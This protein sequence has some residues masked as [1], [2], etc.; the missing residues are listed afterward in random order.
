MN[1]E[2]NTIKHFPKHHAVKSVDCFNVEPNATDLK[3]IRVYR[4]LFLFP[5]QYEYSTVFSSFKYEEVKREF[6][7]LKDRD[8]TCKVVFVTY[9]GYIQTMFHHISTIKDMYKP[10][11]YRKSL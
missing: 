2:K 11:T 3:R 6:Y 7:K 9:T 4:L 8:L 1:N 5:D 10:L